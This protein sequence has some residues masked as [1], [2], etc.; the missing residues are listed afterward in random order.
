VRYGEIK[1]QVPGATAGSGI[2]DPPLLLNS[3]KDKI[4]KQEAD[5]PNEPAGERSAY[6]EL[7]IKLKRS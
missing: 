1:V 4:D 5:S 6:I 7:K 3:Q 2:L